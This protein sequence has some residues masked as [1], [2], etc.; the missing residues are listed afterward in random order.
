MVCTFHHHA[1]DEESAVFP[2]AARFQGGL[3]AALVDEHHGLT[4]RELEITKSAHQILDMKDA[5]M[6]IAAGVQLNQSANALL[7]AYITHMNREETELVPAMREH[8]TDAQQAAMR[9]LI[10]GRMPPERLFAIL[11]WMLPSLNVTELT[12]LLSSI[13][14]TAPAPLLAAVT[15]LCADRV[16]P[17]RWGAVKAR[18]GL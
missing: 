12:D 18:A 17:T 5:G 15:R 4:R 14:K 3:I 8:F 9:G 10:I 7:A 6:R 2:A 1:E 16:D 13:K 11:G